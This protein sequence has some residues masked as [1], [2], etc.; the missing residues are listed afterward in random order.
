MK[1]I[2]LVCCFFLLIFYQSHSQSEKNIHEWLPA[3]VNN[4]NAG[5]EF[6]LTFHPCWESSGTDNYIMLYIISKKATDVTVRVNAKGYEQTQ[7]TVPNEITV[8]SLHPAIAQPYAKDDR[9]KPEDDQVWVE[10]G[11]HITSESPIICYAFT[12]YQYTSDGYL[13]IPVNTFGKEY[14]I[15]SWTDIGSNQNP[16][17]QYLT[18]YSS[19]VAAYDKTKIRYT[20]GGPSFS[21]TTTGI[22]VGESVVYN[23][24]QGDVLLMASIG[25]Y[26]DLSGSKFTA[27]KPF[28]TV[29]GNFCSYVPEFVAACDFMIEADYPTHSW[30]KTYVVTPIQDRE[31]NSWIKIYAKEAGAKLYRDGEPFGELTHGGGGKIGECYL[32]MRVLDAKEAPRPVVISSDKPIMV[33]QYN[34]GQNDDGV[35]ADPFQMALTPFEQ[36]PKNITLMV[37]DFQLNYVNLVYQVD[38]NE[39]MPSDFEIAECKNDDIEW[40]RVKE[41]YPDMGQKLDEQIDGKTYYSKIITLPGDGVYMLRANT[42]FAAYSNGKSTYESY[43]FAS[44]ALLNDLQKDDKEAPITDVFLDEF[45]VVR[46]NSNSSDQLVCTDHPED[47]E[48]RSNMSKIVVDYV[49]TSNFKFDHEEFVPGEYRDVLW[50]ASVA[51]TNKPATFVAYFVDRAGNHQ[52]VTLYWK[53]GASVLEEYIA[54]AIEVYPNPSNGIVNIKSNKQDLIIKNIRVLD[55][56]GKQVQTDI[57]DFSKLFLNQLSNG[58]YYLEI[59]TNQGK[60]IKPLVLNK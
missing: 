21:Q 23:M 14:I 26:S 18:S 44:Y 50:S 51:D 54:R 10:A 5:T 57:S 16:G 30:G 29:S 32:S 13:A 31:K 19:A 39:T 24:N 27:N 43:G 53:G 2:L 34:P 60:T 7:R 40:R 33:V 6:F 55:N 48:Y 46:N 4:S 1:K 41:V 58:F 28:T 47:E 22:K 45:G 42:P 3:L 38:E 9:D 35:P 49:F 56:Q 59:T 17:G 36:W 8:F 15:S 11:V 25:A 37:E 12:Q 20:G 52:T